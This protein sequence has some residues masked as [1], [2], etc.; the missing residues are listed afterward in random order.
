MSSGGAVS[1]R[2]CYQQGEIGEIESRAGGKDKILEKWTRLMN[3]VKEI[4]ER[5][6][7]ILI[8]GDMNRHIGCGNYGVPGNSYEVSYGGKL[9]RELL[10]T[11]DFVLLNGLSLAEGGPWTWVKRGDASCRSCL[12]LAIASTNLAPY[13]TKVKIDSQKEFTPRRVMRRKGKLKTVYS[14]GDGWIA[15]GLLPAGW[16][17]AIMEPPETR[18]LGGL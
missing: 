11:D 3:D 7:G 16:K 8:I 2:V 5:G 6:E 1:G 15:E 9:L 10:Q 17:Q 13:V 4:K 14:G 12:D 18:E